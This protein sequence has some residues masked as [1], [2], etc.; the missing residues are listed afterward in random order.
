MSMTTIKITSPASDA[1][2]RSARI[3][4]G[5]ISWGV[6]EV[7]GWG[8]QLPP[9]RVLGAMRSLGITATEAGPVGY[10][11]DDAGTVGAVLD[12]AG[13]R[14]VGAFLPVV[15][16]DP[17]LQAETLESARR[18][19]DLLAAVGATHLV[20]A[21]VVDP[22]WSPRVPLD[23]AAWQSVFDGLAQLDELAHAAGLE[24]VLHPHVG[25]L[26]ETDDDLWL[27]LERCGTKICLDTGH[28]TLGGT[29]IVEFAA[30]AGRRV[31]HVHLKDVRA[32]VA[33]R[34]HTG[35]LDLVEATRNGLFC[36]LGEGDV[37]V[38]ETIRALESGGYTGW[39]VL[40]QDTTLETAD[41]SEGAGPMEDAA[42]SIA[43]LCR[44]L[45]EGEGGDSIG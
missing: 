29:D 33:A 31:G 41:V 8:V 19:V 3:A 7:P 10:L 45:A 40:E 4:A 16:H 6:C 14:L 21:V 35:E 17:A 5:P 37:R 22:G 1:S 11:G 32:D 26:V 18:T 28:L 15:L 43:F 39:Y 34:L 24:H 13:L 38:A 36:A 30:T 44:C 12:A 23:D 9:E 20:S 27:V 2:M 42:R 25:T